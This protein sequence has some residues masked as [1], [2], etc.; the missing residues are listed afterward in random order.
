MQEDEEQ[1]GV[2]WWGIFTKVMAITGTFAFGGIALFENIKNRIFVKEEGEINPT[3]NI[4]TEEQ[5]T[6]M[7]NQEA[8]INQP[9]I[10]RNL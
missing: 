7:N 9:P 10:M 3:L 8:Y 1:I 6:I 2:N 4:N 5:I